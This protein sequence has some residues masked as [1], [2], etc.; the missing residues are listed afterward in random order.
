MPT[1]KNTPQLWMKI[2]VDYY[3]NPKIIEA[4]PIAELAYLR[5]IAIARERIEI[6]EVD[7]AVPW[8]L[9]R[10]E[11]RDLLDVSTAATIEE[12]LA[13]LATTQLIDLKDDTVIVLDYGRWQTTRSELE[14]TRKNARDRQQRRA[15]KVASTTTKLSSDSR[16]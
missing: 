7:G 12:L 5:L 3:R 9:V 16:L 13:P 1:P 11:L 8:P 10:R 15:A 14:S 6:S 4:G 2:A